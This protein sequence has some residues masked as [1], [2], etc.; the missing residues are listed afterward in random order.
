MVLPFT[1]TRAVRE[2]AGDPRPSLAERYPDH[3]AYVQAVAAAAGRLRD[4][5]LL[6]PEDAERYVKAARDSDVGN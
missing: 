5:R 3:A 1:R 4:Q 2:A 6:L